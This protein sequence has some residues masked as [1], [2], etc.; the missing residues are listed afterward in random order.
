[1]YTILFDDGTLTITPAPLIVTANGATRLY[2]QPNP[3]LSASY[4]GLL[5]SDT[6]ASLAGTL[7]FTIAAT[8]SS[9][10]GAY[11][12][13]PGSPTSSHDTITFIDGTLNITPAPLI[14]TANDA[15]RI[16]GQP[17]PVFSITYSGLVNGDTAAIFTGAL[18]TV[19]NAGSPVGDYAID[20]G[21][22]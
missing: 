2:G 19:A 10:V 13:T 6:P 4:S 21:S 5:N 7:G 11:A 16:Y 17:N 22:F 1:N 9:P 18:A 3:A 14:V 12:L 8:Q 15:T 20:R